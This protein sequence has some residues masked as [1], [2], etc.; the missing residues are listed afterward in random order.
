MV[1]TVKGMSAVPHET[2]LFPARSI[3]WGGF[4]AYFVLLAITCFLFKR[5][6]TTELILIVGWAMMELSEI[7]ALYGAGRF[8]LKAAVI[9]SVMIGLAAVI[10]LLCY[11]LYYRL[12]QTAGYIDGMI[13]LIIVT[14]VMAGI[15]VTMAV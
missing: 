7:D 5:Q 9:L 3:L 10:S 2:K 15:S 4:A 11:V 1:L 6:V 8:G 12:E 14:L 13:P